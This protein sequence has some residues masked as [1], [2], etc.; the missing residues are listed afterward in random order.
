MIYQFGKLFFYLSYTFLGDDI[1]QEIIPYEKDIKF[2]T[3][4]SEITSISL[5]HEEDLKSDDIEGLFIVSGDYKVHPISVNKEEFKYKIPFNIELSDSI[6][7]ESIKLDINDFTYDIKD[8]DTLSIKV[9]LIF[10]YELKEEQLEEELDREIEE[11]ISKPEEVQ[12]AKVEE[13]EPTEEKREVETI[14]ENKEAIQENTYVTYHVYMVTQEDNIES[15]CLKYNI[16]I[17]TLKEYNDFKELNVGDK[18]LIPIKD[19]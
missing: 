2:D 16:D 9:E 3:K 12:E 6:N 5:E 19:E 7:R 10:N 4:I 8:D 14:E 1:M 15:I 17:N 13:L 18:L 11:L